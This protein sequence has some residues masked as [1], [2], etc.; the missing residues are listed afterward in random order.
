MKS[1]IKNISKHQRLYVVLPLMLLPVFILGFWMFN[2]QKQP[3]QNP[4]GGFNMSLPSADFSAV[5]EM[6]DKLSLYEQADKD[7]MLLERARKQDPFYQHGEQVLFPVSEED[8]IGLK[9]T[10]HGSSHYQDPLQEQEA[11]IT[12]RLD[13]LKQELQKMPDSKPISS[14]QKPSLPTMKDATPEDQELQRLEKMMTLLTT[15]GGEDAEMQQIDHMLDKIIAIQHPEQLAESTHTDKPAYVMEAANRKEAREQRIENQSLPASP[16]LHESQS[17]K[18]HNRFYGLQ[19][20]A[21]SE[22]AA[23]NLIEAVIHDHQKVMP[24][25][26]VKLRLLTDSYIQGR[27]IKRGTLVYGESRMSN[28][29][30]EVK[31]QEV[32]RG[33][34]LLPVAL[35]VHDLDGLEGISIPEA[36]VQ[37]S[38]Q[39]AAGRYAQGM[40]LLSMDTSLAAQAAQSGVD[41]LKDVVSKKTRLKKVYLPDNYKVYLHNTTISL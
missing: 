14:P 7:S 3:P 31:V 8:T 25:A 1:I 36:H 22:G 39:S 40:Q 13:L 5:G 21:I 37:E 26:P 20:E 11:Q 12:E 2:Q 17:V 34:E 38:V 30:L 35:S 41:A 16:T 19:E 24:G 28:G 9:T 6:W 32:R 23:G 27:L 29:R 18:S 15:S 33:E 10:L 4:Y